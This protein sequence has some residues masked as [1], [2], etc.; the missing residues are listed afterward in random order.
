MIEIESIGSFE[1][2]SQFLERMSRGDILKSLD[3]Y[4]RK[5]VDALSSATPK[6]SGTT[7]SSW[8]YEVV[9]KSGYYAI[10]WSNSHV[11]DG[12][13][14]AVIL[15]YGHATRSGSFIQGR[16]YIMPAIRPVFDEITNDIWKEVK[17]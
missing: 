11:V 12:V 8:S 5:G 14:V 17:K 6:D 9:S 7:A 2:T 4:G 1:K 10:I 3:R 15:Q 13:P 16:D